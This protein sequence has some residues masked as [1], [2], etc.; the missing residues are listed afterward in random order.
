MKALLKK[1]L[2]FALALDGA[3][4]VEK[5]VAPHQ[6]RSRL[7]HE[8]HVVFQL[9]QRALA[10]GAVDALRQAA[11]RYGRIGDVPRGL[12]PPRSRLL[13]VALHVVQRRQIGRRHACQRFHRLPHA[14]GKPDGLTV[15]ISA[16][17]L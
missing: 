8:I 1:I 14:H 10:I 7:R 13:C 11:Q 4:E 3:V 2:L 5:V 16:Q 12:L 17:A 9:Q 6:L 15:Q